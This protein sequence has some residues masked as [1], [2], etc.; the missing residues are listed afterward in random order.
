[1]K[2]LLSILAVLLAAL[3]ASAQSGGFNPE[4][5]PEPLLRQQL[6]VKT[7]PENAGYAYGSG[8][9]AEGSNVSV[10]TSGNTG[11][12]FQYWML[13]GTPIEASQN[14][15]Y[16]MTY[17]PTELVAVYKYEF[18]PE[19]PG[20]P[21]SIPVTYR[22]YLDSEPINAGWFNRNSGDAVRPGFGV[23]LSASANS[24]YI[25]DGWYD[26]KGTLISSDASFTYDMPNSNVTLTARFK[27][28]PINPGDPIGSQDNVSNTPERGDVN[29][30]G[31]VDVADIVE[32]VN[33][34]NNKPS[35][36]FNKDAADANGDK[37]VDLK[38]I[39]FIENIIMGKE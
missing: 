8:M 21:I 22:L 12:T 33:Y 1:M 24:S 7:Q 19:N 25:F 18:N 15:T 32:V 9:Y 23:Y 14:F 29:V 6:T 11:Y 16:T 27:F 34:L 35:K 20:E 3:T 28:S 26:V 10:S 5:P 13:N 30:D 39:Q 38:D 17:K 2:R 37:V 36:R 31:K 4:N